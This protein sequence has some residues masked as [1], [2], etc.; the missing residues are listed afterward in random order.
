[1]L[2][3]N[4]IARWARGIGR[5][6]A[7]ALVLLAFVVW[8]APLNAQDQQAPQFFRN[9]IE[10][11]YLINLER[12]AVGLG[13]L[14]WNAELTMAARDFARDTIENRN[15]SYCG[16][17]DSQNRSAAQRVRAA[18]Y[19]HP[20][21]VAENSLCGYLVAAAAVKGW[22]KSPPHRANILHGDLREAGAGYYR[23]GA[24][25]AVL[26]L[27]L[28]RDYAP[29][30]INNEAPATS[31]PSVQL[32]L[33]DQDAGD[34]WTGVGATQSMMIAN[35]PDFAGAQWE[36]YR[37][38]RAWMLPAG[39][40]WRTVYVKTRDR[41]GR[42]TVVHDS[43]Y[44]GSQIPD[45]ELL[46]AYATEVDTGFVLSSLRA[47]GY[48]H[49]QYSVNWLA[50]DSNENFELLNGSGYRI[51]DAAAVGG[52][53]FRMP[54]GG[55]TAAAMNWATNP[56]GKQA[57]I[58]YFRL[59]IADNSTAQL[60]A[61]L[62]VGDGSKDVAVRRLASDQFAVAGQYQEFAVPFTPS[63]ASNGLLIFTVTRSGA[64]DLDWDVV[65]IYAPPQPAVAPVTFVAPG[66]YY[67]SNGVQARLVAPD[68]GDGFG[69]VFSAP[70]EVHPHRQALGGEPSSS[71]PVLQIKPS[72]LVFNAPNAGGGLLE[73]AVTLVC[74]TCGESVV[75]VVES[76]AAWL[77]VSIVGGQLQVTVD[78]AALLAGSIN[79]ATI[80]ISV[81]GRSDIAAIR[82]P[83]TVLLGQLDV[84]FPNRLYIPAVMRR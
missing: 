20:D 41:L 8:P 1:M 84:L 50:D 77:D 54:G 78:A 26:D 75:W 29:L 46:L 80:T 40:G 55:A 47:E 60:A 2:A 62:V 65:T 25:Y 56:L 76:D 39:Q 74:P 14:A 30:V 63:G 83:V 49:I 81:A 31:D 27:G 58:A 28:D 64:A 18:G 16:H 42:T 10:T 37:V 24:G 69:S 6:F 17:V 3:V 79:S 53:A 73:A 66:E 11:I 9:E 33:Y 52:N 19:S 13:P 22:M 38:E 48:T 72:V 70:I 61:T 7:P 35:T 71:A 45:D 32:Y 43:I 15:D 36:P 51:N 12:R 59:K 5:L 34:D 23:N 44:L 67:R 21:I 82:L 4:F 57:G 68:G